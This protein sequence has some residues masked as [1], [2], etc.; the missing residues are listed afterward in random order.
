MLPTNLNLLEHLFETSPQGVWAVDLAGATIAVNPA[1]C[2]MLGRD[3]RSLLGRSI[4]DLLQEE[5]SALLRQ[6]LNKQML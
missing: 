1:M 3:V 6:T 4:F 5:D 2:R